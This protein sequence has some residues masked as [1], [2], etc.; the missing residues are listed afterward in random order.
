M[1]K[2]L[3][4]R[5]GS[6]FLGAAAVGSGADAGMDAEGRRAMIEALAAEPR[7]DELARKSRSEDALRAEGVPILESLPVI[8]GETRSLR[9]T[10]REVAQRALSAMI[11]AVRG[12]TGD[13]AVGAVLLKDFGAGAWLTPD[14]QAFLADADPDP[15]F[16]TDMT[17]R[18]ERVLVLV[19]AMSLIDTL[20]PGDKVANVSAMG[21][22]FRELGT[23]GLFARARLRPQS[24]I[25]DA[26][27]YY[28]RL[29]WAATNARL[30]DQPAPPG[31]DPGIVVERSRALNWLYGY[32]GQGWDEV[33]A[34]T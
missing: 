6:V 4:G 22:M 18:Y 31:A 21:T 29:N 30:Q 14:E 23:Q 27:D 15:R 24:E 19:W 13:P 34:D 32:A 33:S 17:W 20:P 11:A 28:Y 10:E 5:L 3:L 25:L 26:A 1:R 16:A 7:P 8:A 2:G 9:R 12:E